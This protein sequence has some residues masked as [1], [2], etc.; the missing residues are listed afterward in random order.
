MLQAAKTNLSK[1]SLRCLVKTEKLCCKFWTNNELKAHL[2]WNETSLNTAALEHTRNMGQHKNHTSRV[3]CPLQQSLPS[4]PE[5]VQVMV[6]RACTGAVALTGSGAR[7]LLGFTPVG[8]A[9]A[10]D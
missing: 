4:T 2:C 10:T 7:G 1:K 5:V 6:N 8:P 9:G 3:P